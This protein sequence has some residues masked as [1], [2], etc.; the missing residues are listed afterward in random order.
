MYEIRWHGRAGQGI[1]T[2]SRL[3]AYAAL[4]EGKHV[5]AFP[6][7]GPERLGAPMSGYT[8]VSN[9]PIQVHDLI[10]DPDIVVVLDDTVPRIVNVTQGLKQSGKLLINSKE[11]PSVFRDKSNLS[12]KCYTVD[13]EKISFDILGNARAFNTA[14]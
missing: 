5:Q 4:L 8:R 12:V 7:F 14:M 13:A 1:M 11:D 3:L 2:V 10:Y 6:N 9:T